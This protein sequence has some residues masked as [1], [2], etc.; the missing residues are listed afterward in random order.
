MYIVPESGCPTFALMWVTDL[1]CAGVGDSGIRG[2]GQPLILVCDCEFYF[3]S[4]R[5]QGLA[6]K[7]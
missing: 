4:A 5:V 3:S 1:N 6:G 2:D 7:S